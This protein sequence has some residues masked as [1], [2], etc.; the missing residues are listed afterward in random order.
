MF[1]CALKKSAFQFSIGLGNFPNY[2]FHY[3]LLNFLNEESRGGNPS[4]DF[5]SDI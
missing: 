2:L 3:L 1:N 4:A 5:S